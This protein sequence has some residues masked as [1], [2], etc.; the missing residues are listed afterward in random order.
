VVFFSGAL[1]GKMSVGGERP[2]TG[3]T[4]KAC[5]MCAMSATQKQAVMAQAVNLGNASVPA[6]VDE[7]YKPAVAA[8]YRYAFITAYAKILRIAAV[9]AWLGALMAVVFVK[10]ARV[11]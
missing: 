8:A 3:P 4:R 9:L 5:A 10:K 1:T 6:V 7:K 2:D 11:T